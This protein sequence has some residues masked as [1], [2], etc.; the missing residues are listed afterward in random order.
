MSP[1]YWV[2]L[3]LACIALAAPADELAFM[4]SRMARQYDRV[5][6][7]VLAFYY[8]WYGTPDYFG[9]WSHWDKIDLPN[10]DIG[11][12]THFPQLGA[13]DSHNPK[14]IAQHLD[15]AKQAGLTGLICTWWAPGDIHDTALPMVLDAAADRGLEVTI[16]LETT[17][18]S[19]K[20]KVES[21]VS[22]LTYVLTK[23]GRHPAF[24]KVEGKPVIFLYGRVMAEVPAADWQTILETTEQ[25]AGDAI[26]I[27]DGYKDTFA[28]VFDG[29]HTYNIAGALRN[30]D[31][32]GV[33]AYAETAFPSAVAMA[34]RRHRISC[35]TIIPGYDDTK[36]RKPGLA[37]PRNDGE[38]YRIN[39][40]EAIKADPDWVL[41]TSFNEWHEGSEIEPS[42]E[43][44]RKY[45]DLTAEFAPKFAALPPVSVPAVVPGS[46]SRERAAA[47]QRRYAGKT[48]G[49][50]PG[51]SSSL[52][53]WLLDAG[54]NLKVLK[55][56]ELLDPQVMD[57]ATLPV[58]VNASGEDYLDTFHQ[59]GDAIA[60]IVGWQQRGGLLISATS[61]PYPFYRPLDA[62]TANVKAGQVGLMVQQGWEEPP[63]GA[64]L[65]FR[66]NADALPK[67]TTS[68]PFPT[69]GDVR[70]RP[71]MQSAARPGDTY[72]PLATLV[73]GA[74]KSYG[75]GVAY[76]QRGQAKAIYA[77]MRM[78]EAYGANELYEAL[79]LFAAEKLG[80]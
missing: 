77:W 10:R 3:V 60:A 8:T 23:Y 35:L 2:L 44:G 79:M 53:T 37:A 64:T 66:T 56:P 65:T 69:S 51:F 47:L 15:W 45:L 70:W 27:A 52:P 36:I 62:D 33:Q 48:I 42:W 72:L 18:R 12:S 30:K 57:P 22:D 14:V 43:D 40:R 17:T 41:I 4:K 68:A 20:T 46:L 1:R 71:S 7:H 75:D 58:L 38:T 63:A 28:H 6:R 21:A 73:D 9:R 61:L 59:P 32:A 16:Y 26:Y 29:I 31:A 11:S 19:Q 49:I 54:L 5:P 74:G 67:L 39:W 55:P 76:W 78:G 80:L 34:R 25:V 24:L 50:L 13:Y